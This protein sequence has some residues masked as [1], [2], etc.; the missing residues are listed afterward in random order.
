VLIIKIIVNYK[1]QFHKIM[2]NSMKLTFAIILL[3][4][5]LFSLQA[6]S[7]EGLDHQVLSILNDEPVAN[8]GVDQ[9]ITLPTNSVTLTGSGSEKRGT[10]SGY[11]WVKI[12]GP[13]SCTIVS[14][15]SATTV[16]KNL[17]EGIYTFSLQVTGKRGATA[18]DSVNIT[19]KA[20]PPTANAGTNQTIT[21]PLTNV[22][23]TGSGTVQGGTISS[24]K[25]S[26]VSGPKGDVV[27]SPSTAKTAVYQLA[28]GNYAFSLTVTD[29]YG[30]TGS[31]TV[32]VTVNQPPTANAGT[33]QTITLPTNSVTLTGTGT[34]VDGT[35]SSYAWSKVSGPTGGTIVSPSS[36]K[37]VINSLVQGTYIFA[38][39]V[40]D[41][42]GA[43][44][45][46]SVVVTVKAAVNQPPTANAGA[47]QIISLPTNSVT[48]TGTGTDVDGTISSYAWSKVSGPTGATIVSPSSAKTVVNSLVKGTY[49]F[50]LKVTDNDGATG[51]DSVV[52]TVNEPPTANAGTD[53]TITLPTN[54]VTL[55]GTGTD[56][57]GTISS[58]AWTKVSGPSGATIVSPSSA[59]TVINSLVQGI[60]TFALKVTD[61]DGATGSDS[62]VVTVKPAT[63]QPPTANAGTDQTITL[64]TNSVTLTGTG[65]DVDGTISSYA[66][67]KVSG[68]TGGTI[69]SPSSAQTVVKSLAQGTY[70]FSLTVTDNDGATGSDNVVITV[71]PAITSPSCNAKSP[72]TYII[73]PVNGGIYQITPDSAWK[74]GDTLK[75]NAAVFTDIIEFD[76]LHG[77]PCRP[78]VIINSGGV[79]S[80]PAIRLKSDC[81]YVRLTGTGTPGVPYGFKT[82]SG[83]LSVD[84]GHHL[85]FDHVEVTNPVNGVGMW[86]K[87]DPDTTNPITVYIPG[88]NNYV[89]NKFYIH[90][91]WIHDT[92]GEGMYIGHTAPDGG[93]GQTGTY[94]DGSNIL[95]LRMDSIEIAY[96]IVERTAWD[97]IQL[98][99]AKDGAKIHDNIVKNYGTLNMGD[100]QA[101]IILGG[102]TRGAVYNNTILDGTGNG[103]EL[104]GYGTNY[105]YNNFMD[106]TGHDGTQIGQES[107]FANDLPVASEPSDSM[108]QI[109]LYYDTINHPMPKAA[110][111]VGA[112]YNNSLAS[113]VHDN[114]F[115][116]PGALQNWQT[117]YIA[118]NPAGSINSNNVLACLTGGL[119]L[120]TRP[121]N[122]AELLLNNTL[123]LKIY[124]N[125]VQ[126][127]LMVELNATSANQSV[128]ISLTDVQGRVLY[129]K[130]ILLN[131]QLTNTEVDMSRLN[132]G[133]YFLNAKTASKSITE[134]V[135]KI[136]N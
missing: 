127:D 116:I 44:G 19:V 54:S 15:S 113:N 11:A 90:N 110:I 45:S 26:Q 71:N 3:C 76:H 29:N 16:V 7:Q 60:Y 136:S 43:T 95:P 8:A 53:Q 108:Q 67:T 123:A 62:V 87:C 1:I 125:P 69:V 50:A 25:W 135:L 17:I 117:T 21:L 66:W 82:T 104:F 52:I 105:C 27:N 14:P 122:S 46:D 41:N 93:D 94:P 22:M 83:P 134:K 5:S 111:R 100:Q 115:C 9:T 56:V 35:I 128:S 55:T 12:S 109:T 107:I 72:V 4:T 88:A 102:N 32:I 68:P 28:H 73:T 130:D 34:D 96:N 2:K 78:I 112:D 31:D 74:G 61:N 20:T 101:G 80:T 124:P 103:I 132:A 47:N 114:K 86:M 39:K 98:S 121:D 79:V 64:P 106:S 36:A 84:Y 91:C 40:T 65:A 118:L 70:T 129:K 33:D 24:Y 120:L 30:A 81:E 133:V 23:L 131:Q 89:L 38:L 10:I 58:Y 51:S 59:K 49:T 42:D 92:N 97:G 57:D 77:D 75:I 37:T 18:S 63:N 99:N 119:Q 6:K 85:E 126:S 48:L 13:T